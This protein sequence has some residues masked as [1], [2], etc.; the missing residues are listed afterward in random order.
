MARGT[1]VGMDV[2]PCDTSPLDLEEALPMQRIFWRLEWVLFAIIVLVMAASLAGLFGDGW[3]S[4]TE[5]TSGDVTVRY[6]QFVRLDKGTIVEVALAGGEIAFSRDYFS[7]FRL[8]QVVPTPTAERID[9][10]ELVFAFDAGPGRFTARFY[11]VPLNPGGWTTA[12]VRNGDER[13]DI[14]QFTFP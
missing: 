9:G 10:D 12:T 11:L 5:S 1:V 3:L 2:E 4:R 13:L 14:S 8:E 7:D 6:E